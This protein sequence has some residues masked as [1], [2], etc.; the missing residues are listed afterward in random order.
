MA[1]TTS[2]KVSHYAYDPSLPVAI[3]AAVLYG[4]AFI[5]TFFLWIRTKAWVWVMM[6]VAAASKS[7]RVSISLSMTDCEVSEDNYMLF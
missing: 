6:V 7:F 5:L 1:S 4:V 3:V 2:Q